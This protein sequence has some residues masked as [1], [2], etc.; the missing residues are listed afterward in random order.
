MA[1]YRLIPVNVWDTDKFIE[2]SIPAKLLWFYL[3]T[4]RRAT[5]AGIYRIPKRVIAIETGLGQADLEALLAELQQQGLLAHE[6]ELIWVFG[7]RESLRSN[8][9]KLKS[10]IESDLRDIPPSPLKNKYLEY[11]GYPIEPLPSVTDRV[12]TD[13]GLNNTLQDITLEEITL[14]DEDVT[15][16]DTLLETGEDPFADLPD[17]TSWADCACQFRRM[18][19]AQSRFAIK[20]IEN[21]L[22]EAFAASHTPRQVL[23]RINYLGTHGVGDCK[24][25]EIFAIEPSGVP[26]VEETKR[27]L[28]EEWG[29]VENTTAES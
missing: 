23:N 15:A 26:S 5:V 17:I 27:M 3:N 14:E 2:L 28:S 9:Q 13:G 16:T 24:P 4:N 25:W 12:S 19:P 22:K 10:R 29:S 6:G 7:L 18:F 1:D 11:Y 21:Q 8:S 20:T